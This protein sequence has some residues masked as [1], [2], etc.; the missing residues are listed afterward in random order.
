MRLF[1]AAACSFPLLACAPDPEQSTALAMNETADAAAAAVEGD[2]MEV[3]RTV[4]R[5]PTPGQADLFTADVTITPLFDPKGQSQ[6]G[7]AHVRFEPGAAR[8]GTGTLWGSAWSSSKEAAGRRSK[9]GR[10]RR[11]GPAMSSG[12]RPVCATGMAQPRPP[13]WPTSRSRNPRTARPSSGWSMCRT[14]P[15]APDLRDA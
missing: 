15:T 7:E 9:T 13:P 6:V 1:F 3:S 11:S 8:L 2:T 5:S 14:K 12:A 4:A 10:S